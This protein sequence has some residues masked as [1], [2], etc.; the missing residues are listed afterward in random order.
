MEGYPP[1]SLAVKQAHRDMV[2]ALLRDTSGML[3]GWDE[4]FVQGIKEMMH[5]RLWPKQVQK[6]EQLAIII[7]HDSR[8]AIK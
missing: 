2:T 8:G 4:Q 1:K 6:L 5:R 7:G 3:S